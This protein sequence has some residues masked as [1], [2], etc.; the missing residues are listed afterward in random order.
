M[1]DSYWLQTM[2]AAKNAKLQA[3]KGIFKPSL[4][5]HKPMLEYCTLQSKGLL[6][7]YSFVQRA[8]ILI[9]K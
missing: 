1:K 7:N 3:Q 4:P 2:M 8:K 5:L 6:Q 9:L